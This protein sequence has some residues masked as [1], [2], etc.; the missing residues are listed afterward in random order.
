[1]AKRINRTLGE[2][3]QV[4]N[5]MGIRELEEDHEFDVL[6]EIREKFHKKMGTRELEYDPDPNE[7]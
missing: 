7:L 4:F 5:T 1:M 2:I 3:A 6:M